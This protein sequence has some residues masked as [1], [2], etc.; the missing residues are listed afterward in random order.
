MSRVL[1]GL[2]IREQDG[3]FRVAAAAGMEREAL[4]KSV[5]HHLYSR[6]EPILLTSATITSKNLISGIDA[7]VQRIV[8][9][10]Y[11][12]KVFENS[13]RS[14]KDILVI[15]KPRYRDVKL[16]FPHVAANKYILITVARTLDKERSQ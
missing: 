6:R 15:T 8:E 14:T 12:Q 2:D 10:L 1:I 4:S 7:C 16:S 13:D 5:E 11:L 3:R 9:K